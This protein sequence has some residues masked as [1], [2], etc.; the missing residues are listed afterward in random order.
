VLGECVECW[1]HISHS[2]RILCLIVKLGLG[3]GLTMS[4]VSLLFNAITLL[5]LLFFLFIA[6][7]LLF[8]IIILFPLL[9]FFFFFFLL[10]L[11]SHGVALFL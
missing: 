2:H 6:I 3:E 8:I 11:F 4:R 7:T 1:S 5:P 9:L 10:L